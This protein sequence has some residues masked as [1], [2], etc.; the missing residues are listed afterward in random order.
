MVLFQLDIARFVTI[1]IA[2]GIVFVIFLLIVYLILKRDKKWLNWCFSGTY[3]S[4]CVG[5]FLNFI[6]APLTDPNIVLILYFFTVYFFGYGIIFLVVFEFI[7]L[8]SEKIITRKK[9]LTIFIAYAAVL[10]CMIF[11]LFIPNAGIKIDAETSWRP[12][13]YAPFYIY[14]MAVQVIMGQGPAMYLSFQ[15]YKRFED[16][17]L[18]KKWKFY[19]IGTIELIA[20]MDILFTANFLNDPT[21]RTIVGVLGLIFS[22]SGGYLMYFGVGRQ[23]EK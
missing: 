7:V 18:K 17:K 20:F 3:L 19:I 15:I 2:Q 14:F 4:V 16:P 10:F 1:Y 11:F 6:Y 13:Y 9:Q 22:I 21:L 5:L 23:I 8:K 12:V